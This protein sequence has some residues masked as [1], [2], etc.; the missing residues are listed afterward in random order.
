MSKFSTLPTSK[1]S[2]LWPAERPLLMALGG[3]VSS[4]PPTIPQIAD[5]D[6]GKVQVRDT[7]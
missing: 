1:A 4:K 6:I 3:I 5:I 7:A 2:V